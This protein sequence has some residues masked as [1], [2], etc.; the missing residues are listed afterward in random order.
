MELVKSSPTMP[1]VRY[2]AVVYHHNHKLKTRLLI[3]LELKSESL[4]QNLLQNPYAT[5]K[6][7]ATEDIWIKP[8]EILTGGVVQRAVQ[9]E[10][11][12]LMAPVAVHVLKFQIT[13]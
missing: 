3:V 1:L 11:T 8:M 2:A 12:D 13:A 6:E 10:P 4:V 5:V 9:E 7:S